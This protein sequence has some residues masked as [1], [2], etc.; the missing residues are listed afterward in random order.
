MT[1]TIPTP[2]RVNGKVRGEFYPLQKEEL[3][4]LRKAKLINN[5]AY[6]HLA[7]R[8][9]NPYCDRPIEIIPKE[10][11]LRWL[12]PESSVYEAIAKLQKV[13][14]LPDLVGIRTKQS[15]ET[16]IRDRLHS[17]L[18]GLIEISTAAGRID[19]LTET[20]IIEIKNIK[21]WKAALGQILVYSAFYLNHQKRIHLFGSQA[22]LEKLHDLEAACL[23]F[24]VNVTAEEV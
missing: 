5:A 18:G 13:G 24:N 6:V 3:I 12:L 8:F 14:L 16:Q 4:A 1:Q 23:S 22:E 19:L 20:E 10:F 11:A 21:D 15:I 2:Q 9:E 17:E 7:L